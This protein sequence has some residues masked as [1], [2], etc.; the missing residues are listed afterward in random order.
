MHVLDDDEQLSPNVH[1]VV[2]VHES[3]AVFPAIH[4]DP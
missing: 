3:F 1:S 2:A 4:F